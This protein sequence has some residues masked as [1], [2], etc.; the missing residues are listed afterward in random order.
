MRWG[1]R[2][3]ACE[4]RREPQCNH[5]RHGGCKQRAGNARRCRR[6]RHALRRKVRK[7]KTDEEVQA[8]QPAQLRC[9]LDGLLLTTTVVDATPTGIWTSTWSVLRVLAGRATTRSPSP[10]RWPF[11]AFTVT[12]SLPSHVCEILFHEARYAGRHAGA[13]TQAHTHTT[14]TRNGAAG[15]HET[16]GQA[17]LQLGPR[18]C[19]R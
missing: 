12:S 5:V 6:C 17:A 7:S 16:A 15:C 10:S 8:T 1:R 2:Y 11:G 3:S 9:R 14:C 19:V 18:A 4:Q 13:S